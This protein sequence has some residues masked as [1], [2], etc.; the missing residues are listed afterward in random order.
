[1]KK[2]RLL[3][4]KDCDRKCKGCCNNDW[5]LDTLPIAKKFKGY[6]QILLTGGEPMLDPWHVIN[7]VSRIR[8]LSDYGTQIFLYTAKT[9]P[10]AILMWV[11]SMIDGVTITLHK[12]SDVKPFL[13]F[14]DKAKRLGWVGVKSLRLN[15]FKG[16]KLRYPK[17]W[18][19]KDKM[20]WQKNCPL[21]KDEVF[22]RW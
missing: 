15:V 14:A 3:I 9:D 11:L 19:V 17:G 22:M 6:Y 4:T 10:Y 8:A 12:Q 2:L 21:P 13:I 16:I 20:V 5:D 1:M 7:V 18:I